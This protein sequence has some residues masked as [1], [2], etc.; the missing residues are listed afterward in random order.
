VLK[1]IAS[2]GYQSRKSL[3]N[4]FRIGEGLVGQAALERKPIL[5]TEA[6]VDYIKISSGLG[7][8]SPVNLVVL[9]IIFEGELLAVIELASFKPFSETHQTFLEQLTETI[10]VTLNTIMA[11]MRT[12]TL[13]TQSQS[14]TQELQSQSEELQTQQDKLKRSNSELE[15][16]THSLKASEELLQTQQED[17]HQT[18][19]ELQEKAKQLGEQNRDIETKNEEIELA[20]RG[21]EE[22]AEQLAL[23]SK[24]KS[25]FL[26]NMSHELRTPLN[27]LLI[28]SK[29]LADNAEQNLTEKQVEFAGTIHTSGSD[30]L[31]LI[32]DI[33]DLSKVE[34]GKM[35][36]SI[37]PVTLSDVGGRIERTFRE[38]AEQKGLAFA[39][40]LDERVGPTI[41]TDAQ[42]L[43]QVLRNLLS[44][45]V[46]FTDSGKVVLR[47]GRPAADQWFATETLS[48]AEQVVAFTVDDTG[49]GIGADKLN[50]VFEAF[51]QADGTTNR[52][53]GG[54]GLG[55]SISR[56]ISHLLGGEIAATS[57]L[58]EGSSFTLFLPASHEA[59]QDRA[60]PIALGSNVSAAPESGVEGALRAAVPTVA[61]APAMS[62]STASTPPPEVPIPPGPAELPDDRDLIVPGDRVS[63]VIEDDAAFAK[64]VA[65]VSRERGYKA[66]VALGGDS[67]LAL[68][69]SYKPDVIFLDL[70][71]PTS[72]G[73][74]VLD[75]LKRHSD[76]RHIPVYVVSA[77][78]ERHALASV[79]AAGY[80][81][82]PA[83][84]HALLEQVDDATRLIE[85]A[86]KPVLVV[87]A[88]EAKRMSVTELIG[89]DDVV[90]T[91]VTSSEDALKQLE[92]TRFGCMVLDLGLRDGFDLLDTLK[93][94]ERFSAM[95]VVVSSNKLLT[96]S[97][98]A[99]LKGYAET[100]VVRAAGSPERVLDETMLVL[101]RPEA[102]LPEGKRA[103]LEHLHTSDELFQGK[104]ILVVDDD[105]RY[106]FALTNALESRGMDVLY[107]ENGHGAL[108]VLR[109]EPNVDLVLMDVMM[110]G[111]DGYQAMRMVRG[112]PGFENLPIISVTAKSAEGDR[113]K[114]IAWGASD[115]IAK[116]VDVG[117]LLSLMGVW[118]YRSAVMG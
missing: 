51:Q 2:Y 39:V 72:S 89:G 31:T 33:L 34:A 85:C 77:V 22:K 111:T 102:S 78:G 74:A 32:N 110:P 75:H 36:V 95:P 68:A 60:E 20:S 21:L 27:S 64:L 14:L 1:L 63:L 83:T 91:G 35:D 112:M 43:E 40:E 62:P 65:A 116:P 84:R 5:I 30:L 58:G 76:V 103:M 23:S 53:F 50:L 79:G 113:E 90:V 4:R 93:R 7:E 13:L 109:R 106:V 105:M 45:A 107:A 108:E 8:A 24:Y 29:L 99:R 100:L 97:E 6:P 26:A 80:L 42:R 9:P 10:G 82:K 57:T 56:E 101:H 55:L 94:D 88:D 59:S 71:L 46:K 61:H 47:V 49:V 41:E 66:L 117:R 48:Q 19:D 73:F 92:D 11:T 115:Y 69:H 25:E 3:S 12:E 96:H 98:E 17:L 38:V 15:A 28:L 44:N 114:S 54:T 70:S 81:R 67:G 104:R 86:A 37:A 18:N 52:S 16:Q 87:A 118:L